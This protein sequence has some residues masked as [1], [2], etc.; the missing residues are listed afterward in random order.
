MM[1]AAADDHRTPVDRVLDA[2]RAHGKKVTGGPIQFN[3][4]CPAHD[5]RN[6]SLGVRAGDNGGALVCCQAGCTWQMVAH[7]LDLTAG[8]LFPPRPAELAR[9]RKVRSFQYRAADGTVVVTVSRWEGE[10]PKFTR[11]PAG[12][13]HIPLYNLPEVLAAI[14]DGRWVIVCEGERDAETAGMLWAD[15][16]G[17]G[18]TNISGAGHRWSREEIETLRGAKVVIVGDNDTAG[19]GRVDT[20]MIELA[21]V[22]ATLIARYPAEGRKDLTEH[23]QKGLGRDELRSSDE[24]VGDVAADV[25]DEVE[26]APSD[27]VTRAHVI[28]WSEFWHADHATEEWIAEPVIPGGGRAIALYAPAK[29]GKSLVTL[30]IAAAVATGGRIMGRPNHTGPR[31]VLYVDYEMTLADL[32]ER[33]S[34]M[35]YGPDVDMSHLHYAQLPSL[36]PLDTKEGG[37]QLA[38]LAALYGA[39]LVIIDTMGRAIAGEENDADTVRNFYSYTGLLLK[40]AGRTYL[41]ADHAGK[42]VTKGQR[43]TSA[44]NDDVDLVWQL[45]AMEGSVRLTRTHSRVAWVPETVD[46]L[47][48]DDPLRFDVA[49]HER[50]W[51]KGTKEMAARLD[52]AGVPLDASRR[53]AADALRATSPEGK[54]G[55]GQVVAA[56]LEWRRREANWT[57]GLADRAVDNPVDNNGNHLG[58][59]PR[60]MEPGTTSGTTLENAPSPGR[61]PL[62]NHREPLAEPKW[63][64]GVVTNKEPPRSQADPEPFIDPWEDF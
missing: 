43:G 30:S 10:G 12:V 59:H 51:P 28:D 16:G 1:S 21:G 64:P 48:L 40:Q 15:L 63:E 60:G 20:L 14:R 52:D 44:K 36:E 2:L 61:E 29:S 55:R 31:H 38:E 49:D 42:D 4:Q 11:D 27:L 50:V 24:A 8:D 47:K 56:A 58:N 46:L 45:V 32:Q 37:R 6:P 18:T 53:Q 54:G 9:R 33:L 13:R 23:V 5:D 22:A 41:R 57:T 62:G 19:R 35:G 39:E 7:A 34:D 3:A 26:P 17:V 25:L